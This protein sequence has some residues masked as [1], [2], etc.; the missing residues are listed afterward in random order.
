MHEKVLILSKKNFQ[1]RHLICNVLNEKGAKKTIL[2]YGG[3]GGG[4]N[5]KPSNVQLGNVLNVLMK[6]SK[7]SSM[8]S[9]KEWKV[10]WSHQNIDKNY[11]SFFAL[12]FFCE[13]VDHVSLEDLLDDKEIGDFYSL[14]ANSIFYLDSEIEHQV[15]DFYKLVSLFLAKL[16]FY[17]GIYPDFEN[18]LNCSGP[19]SK[20][21]AFK[22]LEGGFECSNCNSLKIRWEY[23]FFFKA[24]TTKFKDYRDFV[25]LEQKQVKQIFTYF[26]QQFQI[27]KDQIKS[28]EFI[29]SG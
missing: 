3:Q 11:K 4:K 28:S 5:H 19:L 29:F 21:G 16:I 10:H 1:D 25:E 2:F 9:S 20:G 23:D 13:L 18:C 15:V 6:S 17:L 26:V 24:L 8:I 7:K 22:L 27:A 12:S 14:L